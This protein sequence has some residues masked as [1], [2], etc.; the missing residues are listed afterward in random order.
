ME[1]QVKFYDES[2]AWGVIMGAD[3]RLYGVRG[4]RRAG[5]PLHVGERV[6]FELEQAPG[7]PRATAL[8]RL[9]RPSPPAQPSVKR[10]PG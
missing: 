1:G 3:G 7:G 10:A 6:M 2:V 5:P 9:G 8:R 4:G